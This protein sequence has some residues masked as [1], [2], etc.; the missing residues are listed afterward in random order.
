[1]TKAKARHQI[2][3]ARRVMRLSDELA[4]ERVRAAVLFTMIRSDPFIWGELLAAL[5]KVKGGEE[6]T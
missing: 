5:E 2:E 3:E 6:R 1:M 4:D